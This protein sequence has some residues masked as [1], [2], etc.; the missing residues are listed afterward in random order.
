M[1]VLSTT[2][3]QGT[4]IVMDGSC[5]QIHFSAICGA[6]KLNN[7]IFY[8]GGHS[9]H[10]DD[11]AMSILKCFRVQLFALNPGDSGKDQP[12]GNGPN[13][14]RRSLYNWGKEKWHQRLSAIKFSLSHTNSTL[15]DARESSIF[16]KLPSPGIASPKQI[17]FLWHH[18][19]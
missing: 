11:R 4:W 2:P 16:S 6:I 12:N 9:S 19:T 7:Q 14:N 1:T 3:H 8:F 5:P 15:V 13:A 10:F 18:L 17:S